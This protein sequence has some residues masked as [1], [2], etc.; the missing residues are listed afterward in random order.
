MTRY[1]IT[2]KSIGS[3]ILENRMTESELLSLRD[4]TTKKSKS[5]AKPSL[6]DEAAAKIHMNADGHPCIPKEMLMACLIN[7]GVFI[8]LDQKRQLSTKESSLLPGLLTLEGDNFPLLL[9][10]TEDESNWGYASWR[11]DIHQGKNPNGGEA[12]CIVRPLF[13]K[14]AIH[15]T[16]LLDTRELPADTYLRLFT[17]AGT[18]V[19]MGDFRPQRKGIFGQ[20]CVTRWEELGEPIEDEELERMLVKV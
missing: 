7:A 1:R 2:L 5:A 20:F 9:P 16:A 11:H 12:V 6:E 14:W 10:G 15:F 18:R 17:L 19:G 13:E 8:R 3:G 4:K